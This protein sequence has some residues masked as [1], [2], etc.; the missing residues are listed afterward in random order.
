MRHVLFVV[1]NHLIGIY[2]IRWF[3]K[4]NKLLN[5]IRLF[6]IIT[7]LWVVNHRRRKRGPGGV[8]QPSF[9]EWE[10]HDP[11]SPLPL[12]NLEDILCKQQCNSL[13]TKSLRKLTPCYWEGKNKKVCDF[14]AKM[15]E[16]ILTTAKIQE[17][18]AS[19]LVPHW[20]NAPGPRQRPAA[21]GTLA[22][23]GE[24]LK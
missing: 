20:A 15:N 4:T 23:S 24:N 2:Y 13:V 1:I 6:V 10:W 7:W 14:G 5:S 21:I 16:Y 8:D 17:L 9:V 3:K 12:L 11:T 22:I 18:R 19:P